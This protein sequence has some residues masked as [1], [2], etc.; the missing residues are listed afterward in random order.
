MTQ[1]LDVAENSWYLFNIKQAGFYRVHYADNNWELLTEQLYKDHRAIPLHSRTQILDDLFNLANRA[2]VS[3]DVYL[4]LTKY[5]KKEDQYVVWETTRRA[6][7]YLDRMLAMDESYGAF[8]AYLRTL[9]DDP[10][11]S[12]DWTT[13]KEDKDHMKHMLRLTLTRLACQA[14]HHSCVKMATEYYRNWMLN[15]SQNLI[16]PSLRPA[17]YCTAIRIG[18]Q[19]EWEF[20]K[21]RLLEVDIKEDEKNSILQALSCSRDMWIQLSIKLKYAIHCPI[22]VDN[23][24]V[25]LQLYKLKNPMKP[26]VVESADGRRFDSTH[27][28]LSLK[29]IHAETLAI[30]TLMRSKK[31][32]IMLIVLILSFMLVDDASALS[33]S[34]F[35]ELDSQHTNM[36]TT[37]VTENIGDDNNVSIH[38]S[39]DFRLPRTLFPHFYDLSIQVHLHDNKSQAFFFNGSV[40]IK[41]F[42]NVSTTEFFVHASDNLNVSLDQIHMS[43]LDEKNQTSSYIQIDEVH[44]IEDAECYRI[45]LKTPLQ[46]YTYYNLTFGQFRSDMDYDSDGLYISRYLENGIYKYLASTYMESVYARNV[47]PCW[48]EPEFKA[49]FKVNIVRDENFHSLSNMNLESTEVLYDNWRVDR[50]N[51]SVKMSTYLLAFVVSQ[52]SNIQRTDNRGRNFTVWARPDKIRSAEYALDIGIKLLGYFEDYFGIPYSLPKMD[53]IAIPNSSITAMENWGL[54]TYDE[55]KMLWDAE[56]DSTDTLF[57]VTFSVSHKLAHQWL[58]N[59]VTMKW[60]DNLWLNEGFA[61]FFE[62]IGVQLLHPEWKVDELFILDELMLALDIDTLMLSRPVIYPANT[63]IRIITMFDLITYDKGASL[64][65][66]MEKFMGRSAFQN[67]LKRYLIRNQYK[68]TDEKDL[69]KALSEEWNTQG[70]HLDIGFIMDSWTKQRNYPLVIVK[71]NGSNVFCFEQIRYFQHYGNKSSQTNRDSKLSILFCFGLLVSQHIV[72]YTLFLDATKY[73]NREDEFI[74]WITASRALL[75]INNVLALNENYEDFQAYLRTL[76]DNR[77]RSANWSFVGKGQDLPKIRLDYNVIKIACIAEH[78]LCVNKTTDLFRQWMSKLE[79]NPI[80]PDLRFITYCTAIRHGG[81]EE[82]TFLER[83]LILNETVNEIENENKMLALTCSRD[84]E[85]MKRYL[86]RVRENEN[87]WFTLDYFAQSP[88][89]SQLLWDHLSDVNNFIK[90]K[91]FTESIL[92]ALTKYP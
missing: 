37:S 83:Q 4:N 47:F 64:V 65:W 20:L 23:I 60:W 62:Y 55:N 52:F 31:S 70:N 88:V 53:M 38:P 92:T 16:P 24:V 5:L 43:L 40:T 49:N 91:D 67:G 25:D 26:L 50:Y 41:V 89:G 9:V 13:M 27:H 87:F 32:F 34:N 74:V 19:K 69:W 58:G 57:D 45:K 56:N 10:L 11:K 28:C 2:T 54:I 29:P 6:L 48:D 68:N 78:Q 76:I 77:I 1:T 86:E 21:Q 66:M 8:Q 33:R 71:R 3:Y 17:V 79:T 90:H 44:Y 35:F 61:T 84:Q 82:W 12:V 39:E 30:P 46:P 18:G 85:I 7:S 59:L 42:C 14:E 80:R 73:L 15:P 36:V 51:T 81:Q 72:P 75:Y 63:A 22:L